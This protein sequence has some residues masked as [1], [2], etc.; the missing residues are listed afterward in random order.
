MPIQTKKFIKRCI[1]ESKKREKVLES[2]KHRF[3]HELGE[4]DYYKD[5]L[6]TKEWIK[7]FEWQL[8]YYKITEEN[9]STN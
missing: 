7:A 2:K 6:R 1:K 3:Y 9:E 8:K 5:L 4:E